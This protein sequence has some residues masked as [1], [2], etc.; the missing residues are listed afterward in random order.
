MAS[1][2][3][4]HQTTTI[5][6]SNTVLHI[7]TS[8]NPRATLILQHGFGEYAERYVTSNYNLTNKLISHGISV[9][10]MDMHGHGSSLGT[11]GV[12]HVGKAVSDHLALRQTLGPVFLFGHSLG[13]L[14]TISST[15]TDPQNIRGIILTSPACPASIPR[16]GRLFLGMAA[17]FAPGRDIPLARGPDPLSGAS[18]MKEEVALMEQDAKLLKR[19]IPLLVAA[20]AL[21]EMGKV[22][23]KLRELEVPI[24]VLHGKDDKWTSPED[25]KTF[26]DMIKGTDKKLVLYEGGRHELLNDVQRGEALNEILEFLNGHIE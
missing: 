16:V 9:Y 11:R 6:N 3:P 12:C 8:P 22:R 18:G 5:P 4:D 13:G 1:K 2:P 25:S 24:L 15:I 21:D 14:V 23:E 10:A 7:W 26:V 19:Q 20:T 17:A